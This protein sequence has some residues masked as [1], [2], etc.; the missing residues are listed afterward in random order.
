MGTG[1]TLELSDGRLLGF[2]DVGD[3]TG[4]PVL[5]LHGTPDS[6][7]A[8]HPDDGLAAAAGIR[9]VAFDRPGIGLSSPHRT[10]TAGSVADD[11]V[12]LANHLGIERWHPLAWSAGA[13]FAL[14]LAARHG[15][16]VARVAVAA[17]LVPFAA[18]STE[19]ILDDADGGRHLVAEL[20]AE[21]GAAG[22][23]ELAAPMLAPSPCDDTLA[24]EHILETADGPR[25][26]AL[27][28]I[29][30]AVDSLAAGI[31]DAVAQGP[32]GLIREL[33]LQ[34]CDVDVD[35][36]DVVAPVDLWYG[37][38]DSTAPPA[39]GEWWAT[40]LADARLHVF[41]GEGHLIAL[42]RWEQILTDLTR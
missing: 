7:R 26:A 29:A 1:R 12:A 37:S 38:A 16:R 34:V 41:P 3:P 27:D 15:D 31:V 23:A 25:R 24:R 39:F 19:G 30:G 17:G 32:G 42:T 13:P 5:F 6:R 22:L 36:S 40:T 11:A 35:W 9:L 33:E 21:L 14:A 2:D 10:A 20:G 18:Y 8:R 28:A 4:V